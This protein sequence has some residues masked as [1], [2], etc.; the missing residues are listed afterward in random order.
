M[1]TIDLN[2]IEM[3]LLEEV[4][5][6]FAGELL[7]L[8][9]DDCQRRLDAMGELTSSLLERHAIGKARLRYLDDP[10]TYIGGHGKSRRQELELNGTFGQSIYYHPH[11]IPHLEYFLIGPKLPTA[12]IVE[13]QKLVTPNF[14]SG[15]LKP[16]TTWCRTKARSIGGQASTLAEE[17]LKLAIE[18][19]LGIHYAVMVR[20]AVKKARC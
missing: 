10:E 13:F 7:N 6:L 12:V 8:D 1:Q 19:G 5:P 15:D 14:T 2:E 17:F 16:L 18:S 4:Q 11:F 3:A 20:D 9:Y